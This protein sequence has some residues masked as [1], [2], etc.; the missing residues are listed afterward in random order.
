MPN[1]A[2]PIGTTVLTMD[3]A[4]RIFNAKELLITGD[5]FDAA[6]IQNVKSNQIE[7]ALLGQH[8]IKYSSC[9]YE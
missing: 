3:A 6:I 8:G 9:M 5:F 2:A 4:H 1:D 7:Q